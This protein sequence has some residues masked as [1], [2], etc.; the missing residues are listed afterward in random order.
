M[1]VGGSGGRGIVAT[2]TAMYAMMAKRHC[3]DTG[4]DDGNDDGTASH[5]A[6]ADHAGD[7]GGALASV[8]K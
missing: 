6:D 7:D 2:S 1:R 4:D 8:M 5:G 3:D